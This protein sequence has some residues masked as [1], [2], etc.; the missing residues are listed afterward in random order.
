MK[1][2]IDLALGMDPNLAEGYAALGLYEQ[3]EGNL[4]AALEALERSVAL[5]PNLTDV[6]NWLGNICIHGILDEPKK[7]NF[8]L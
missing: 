5:N 3:R 2:Q 7:A 8:I 6:Y 4:E 1:R